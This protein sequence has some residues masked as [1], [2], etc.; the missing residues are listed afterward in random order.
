MTITRHG[1]RTGPKTG[2][3]KPEN[4]QFLDGRKNNKLTPEMEAAKFPPGVSGNPGGRTAKIF[5]AALLRILEKKVKNDPEDR[6][7]LDAIAQQLVAKASKG[8]LGS[9]REVADRVEGKPLQ[10]QEFGGPDG[11]AIPFLSVPREENERRI[12][13]LL[14]RAAA[15]AGGPDRDSTG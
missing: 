8:D 9:I 4:R 7:L 10:R 14:A 1:Q 2:K 12:A 6:V 3:Q 13:E 15:R 11:G 5:T